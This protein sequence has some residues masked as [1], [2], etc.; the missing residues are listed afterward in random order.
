MS[1][2]NVSSLN[3]AYEGSIKNVFEDTSFAIDT[4]WKLGFV[5]G[6]GA[7]KLLF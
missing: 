5:G 1:L 6:T 4:D 2:I 3:F 7:A